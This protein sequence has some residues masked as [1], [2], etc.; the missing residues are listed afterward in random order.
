VIGRKCWEFPAALPSD[1]Q[2]HNTH[3]ST[4]PATVADWQ[5][6]LDATVL[7][8]GVMTLCFHSHSWIRSAQLVEFIDHA[9]REHGRRV[10]FLTF[11]DALD[12]LNRNLLAGQSLRGPRG[13]D[14]GVRLLDLNRDGYLDV[15]I[16][17]NKLRT[18]RIWHPELSTWLETPFPVLICCPEETEQSPAAGVRFG[19]LRTDGF[20]CALQLTPHVS[21]AWQFDGREWVADDR[22][23]PRCDGAGQ[24][25]YTWIAQRDRGVRLRDLDRDGRCELLLGNESQ[26][27][28]FAWSD[29]EDTWVPLD[30]TLP[31]GTRFV[32]AAGRDAG[33]RLVD[34]NEDGYDDLLFSDSQLYLLRLFVAEATPKSGRKIGWNHQIISGLRS[35]AR[36]SALSAKVRAVPAPSADP[37][38]PVVRGGLYPNN[39]VWFHDRQLYVQNEE[40]SHLPGQVDRRSFPQL[41]RT[42]QPPPRSRP[43][44]SSH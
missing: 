30:Y 38:P 18:T 5:A 2:A 34:L 3:G 9:V 4:N 22:L 26:N 27:A 21:S 19:I 37:I 8:Q 6:T 40:T 13:Q 10:K 39:G 35:A 32:D 25:I 41:L 16:A 24:P 42:G 33:L 14:N 7:K 12:R 17:N 1:W 28:I 43:A 29:R 20:P 36:P 44:E 11:R 23:L 31:A 15:V